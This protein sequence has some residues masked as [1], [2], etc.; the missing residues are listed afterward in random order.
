MLNNITMIP[1][2]KDDENMLKYVSM[3][4]PNEDGHFKW[5]ENHVWHDTIKILE[6]DHEANDSQFIV[7]S[8]ISGK[9]Y[10]MFMKDILSMMKDSIV[11]SGSIQSNFTYVQRGRHY[12]IR[13]V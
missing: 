2:T 7:R 9:K 10:Y 13:K 12:G 8:E 11:E 4:Y 5:I 3:S 6:M 1:V